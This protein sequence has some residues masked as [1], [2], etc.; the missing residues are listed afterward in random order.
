MAEYGLAAKQTEVPHNSDSVQSDLKSRKSDKIERE[1]DRTESGPVGLSSVREISKELLGTI[2]RSPSPSPLKQ[3][4][5]SRSIG[6]QGESAAEA[7]ADLQPFAKPVGPSSAG[8]AEAKAHQ[9][10]DDDDR[11]KLGEDYPGLIAQ[12]DKATVEEGT[13]AEVKCPDRGLM[14]A[15]QNL[16]EMI[17]SKGKG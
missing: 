2:R 7:L 13:A 8:V 10:V 12:L 15:L 9:R 16:E 3:G 4:N 17:S 6:V 11:R 14:R 5:G 1:S